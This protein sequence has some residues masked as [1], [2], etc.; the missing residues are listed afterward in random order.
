MLT[1]MATEIIARKLHLGSELNGR[2]AILCSASSQA[3]PALIPAHPALRAKK[4]LPHPGTGAFLRRSA[5]VQVRP[6]RIPIT[7]CG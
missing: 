1:Y 2:H 3:L 4:E 6:G 5:I 7:A